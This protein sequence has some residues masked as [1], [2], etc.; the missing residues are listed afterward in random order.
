MLW[1]GGGLPQIKLENVD[2][3]QEVIRRKKES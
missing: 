1:E 2:S 3:S